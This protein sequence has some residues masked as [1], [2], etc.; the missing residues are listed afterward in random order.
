[1]ELKPNT[2]LPK[3]H[4]FPYRVRHLLPLGDQYLAAAIGNGFDVYDV[5]TGDLVLQCE[6]AHDGPVTCIIPLYSG[7][8]LLTSSADSSV[9][10]WQ[11]PKH[12]RFAVDPKWGSRSG[13][14]S[15]QG[16]ASRRRAAPHSGANTR[17]ELIGEMLGHSNS[18]V[19][20]VPLSD[21]SFASCAADKFVILW[22]D[23]QQQSELRNNY[24]TFSMLQLHN[25]V[26][27][28]LE[29][30]ASGSISP[31]SARSASSGES[32]P[33]ADASKSPP[34]P[35]VLAAP[36]SPLKNPAGS[37]PMPVSE[38]LQSLALAQPGS[39]QPV[40]ATHVLDYVEVLRLEK[41]LS[42]DEIATELRNSG[43]NPQVVEAVLRRLHSQEAGESGP[44]PNG[45]P[46]P[47]AT[48][49]VAQGASP[50]TQSQPPR[51]S[52]LRNWL[53]S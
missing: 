46:A 15:G 22:K 27:S 19:E 37:S 8:R 52:L 42:P 3:E 39:L 12:L 43:H 38:G 6:N 7:T 18:I 2:S 1:M 20:L 41:Q 33:N 5:L 30:H 53:F 26:K 32:S 21:N 34:R 23:G 10:M 4:T 50:S 29:R 13:G 49:P 51:R 24:A 47:Q 35:H 11:V 17:P 36:A 45:Q 44:A 40:I 9:R 28:R 14:I 16:Q 31:A 48:D 25:A